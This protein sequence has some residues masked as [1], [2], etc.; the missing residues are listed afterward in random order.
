MCTPNLKRAG[1]ICAAVLSFSVAFAIASPTAIAQSFDVTLHVNG[2]ASNASDTNGGSSTAPLKTINAAM[3][4]AINSKRNSTSTRI[5]VY[6]A[7]YRESIN[8]RTYTNFPSNQPNNQTPIRVEAQ[9]PGNKP[10]VSGADVWSSG[11]SQQGNVHSHNWSYNWGVTDAPWTNTI[12]DLTDIVLRREMVYLNNQRLD[13]V[14]NQSDLSPGKFYVDETANRLYVYPPQNVNFGSAIKEV[15]I[16]EELWNQDYENNITIR[17]IVFEKS[18]DP[19]LDARS[20][21][22]IVGSNNV[23]IEDSEFRFSNW[24][25]LYVGVGSGLT[26]RRSKINDNGGRGM[27]MWREKGVLIEDSEALRN[28][29][30]GYLQGSIPNQTPFTGWTTGGTNIESTHDVTVR[31]FNLRDNFT[32]GLWLDTD[33]I[34]ASFDEIDVSNNENDGMFLE[35]VQ[36]PITIS[37]SQFTDN[38]R[39]G[40]FTGMAE[41]VSLIDNTFDRNG[42]S[43]MRISGNNNGRGI[44]NFETNQYQTVLTRYWTMTGNEFLGSGPYLIG[45]TVNSTRW[46]EFVGNLT[47]NNNNWCDEAKTNVFQRDG[48]Q[49]L[50]LAGWR[51]HTGEDSNSTY[52]ADG[53]PT[54]GGDDN[55]ALS[56]T[57]SQSSIAYGGVAS[58]GNDGV[59]GGGFSATTHTG[60][61]QNA[62]WQADLGGNSPLSEI[63]I[64]NRDDCCSSR[65]T[66]FHVFVSSTPFSSTD[67]L[68]TQSQTG[69]RDFAVPGTAARPT[70]IQVGGSG[71]YVRVQL[72]GKNFLN[73]AEV[74]II[75]TGSGGGGNLPPVLTVAN[76][77]S[78]VGSAISYQIVA[79]DPDGDNLNYT[80]TPLPSGLTV[81]ANSGLVTGTLN[82][83]VSTTVNVTVTDGTAQASGSFVWTVSGPTGQPEN[84]ALSATVSQSSTAYDGVPER[85]IDDETNGRYFNSNSVT[86]TGPDTNAWWE[87]DLG[88]VASIDE[89][90]IW[91]RTDCCQS[92]L[93]DFHVLVSVDPFSSKDLSSTIS[94]SGV[95]N[96]FRQGQAAEQNAIP[97]LANGRY[98]R[99]Q[100]SG[101]NFLSMAEVQV[102]ASIGSSSDELT[103]GARNLEQQ[104]PTE[105]GLD[106]AYPNPFDEH[107]TVQLTLPKQSQVRASVYDVTGRVAAVVLER[108]VDAGTM[109]IRWDGHLSSGERAA[110]GLYLIVVDAD[111]KR[112]TQKVLRSH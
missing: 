105:L 52:C 53:P 57:V 79:T 99:V 42:T 26:I 15:A 94:Q 18:T 22:R 45:T 21:V 70:T 72:A 59:T 2:N 84:V 80:A 62:W 43:P 89:I 76:R 4:R 54:T 107:V 29:W 3:S 6:P 14:L 92:R 40:L 56:A 38:L 41:R 34:D 31:R 5:L 27:A 32:R 101:K 111:G 48:G 100:L 68:T 16:R 30:R 17:G 63:R 33:V 87:A 91:S 109:D 93:S 86:H 10:V 64:W 23:T 20:Q 66:N 95:V 85:A 88:Q 78:T 8:L 69:V 7:T 39:H 19:W 13:P 112:L 35:A 82:A 75:G 110:S 24:T 12:N 61:D 9:N 65:V 81:N 73:L 97:V 49:M 104:L 77:S 1:S 51:S 67:F 46:A 58:R 90:V 37:N 74:E 55:L 71:R 98:V 60:H 47:S 83:P 96:I 25:G 50:N 108:A 103:V 106:S 28:N 44:S 11:W 102:M 36:G